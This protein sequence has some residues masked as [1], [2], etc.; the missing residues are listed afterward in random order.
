MVSLSQVKL[1]K[2]IVK[3]N[4]KIFLNGQYVDIKFCLKVKNAQCPES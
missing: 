3:I 2:K 1:F 4:V